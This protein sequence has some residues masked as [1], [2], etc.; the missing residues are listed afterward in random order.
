M[1]RSRRRRSRRS[2]HR[3]TRADGRASREVPEYLAQLRTA[4]SKEDFEFPAQYMF[5]NVPDTRE[6][7]TTR[8]RSLARGDGPLRH[9]AGDARRRRRTDEAAARVGEHPDRFFGE[10][11]GRPEPGHGGGARAR[12]GGRGARRQGGDGVP[13][14]P[15]PAGADQ[16]QEV[17]PAL[18]EVRRARHPDLRVRRRARAARADSRCQD[19][20]LIDEVCWFFPELK[21]VTRHGCEP[22][23]DLAVK[24]MLK[25]PN[26]YYSTSAFAPKYYPKDDHRLR[27]H[28]RR[29]QGD[30]RGLLPDGPVARAHLQRDARRAVP[31]PRVAEVPA[32]ERDATACF[33]L[34]AV[35]AAFEAARVPAASSTPRSASRS[36]A[37]RC[38]SS[39]SSSASGTH[40]AA[41]QGGRRARVPRRLHVQGRARSGRPTRWTTRSRSC[42]P[43]STATTSRRRSS[44][45]TTRSA[46]AR[47]REHPRPVLR[48]A[49]TSTPT[50][51]WRRCARSTATPR[52]STSS[53][54]GAFPPG[55]YP[56]VA[57]NDKKFYPIYMKC[58]ELD[59]AV[60]LDRGRARPAHLATRRRTS[61]TS[62][63]CAGS[64]RS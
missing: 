26:L 36:R 13:R 48:R 30:V 62:T 63:R 16:R 1:R 50:R 61:P 27:E 3:H 45:S 11:R 38:T 37:R 15:D 41:E 29:R 34:T 43:S 25:W 28:A 46:S 17:L 7:A 10:L 35:S 8:S 58:I 6:R 60:L 53:A 12:A 2:D 57:I 54:V 56:Q 33:E 64:S 49:S 18:R 59:V 32:R 24:L 31:R 23:A 9:R 4:K 47:V 20:A 19:V 5:K 44:A 39:T 52:S 51:A 22:W 55:L 42:S 21:F 14:G 40:D